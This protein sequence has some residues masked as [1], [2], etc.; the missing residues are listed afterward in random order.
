MTIVISLDVRLTDQRQFRVV[1]VLHTSISRLT[2]LFFRSF[3]GNLSLNGSAKSGMG[4]CHSRVPRKSPAAPISHR[5]IALPEKNAPFQLD[6]DSSKPPVR[7]GILAW[8]LGRA[9]NLGRKRLLVD[10]LA[11]KRRNSHLWMGNNSCRGTRHNGSSSEKL[12]TAVG[13]K[14]GAI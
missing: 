7:R 6:S 14:T 5:R 1:A 13:R 4:N 10:D 9:A 3:I 12:P 8:L 11:F 2:A